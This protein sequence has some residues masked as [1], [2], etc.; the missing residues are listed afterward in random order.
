[1]GTSSLHCLKLD[2]A[3]RSRA[4]NHLVPSSKM[5]VRTV[6]WQSQRVLMVYRYQD[7]L[8]L[9]LVA[10]GRVIT[11]ARPKKHSIHPAGNV[12]PIQFAV[13]Y[14]SFSVDLHILMNTAH[15]PSIMNSSASAS[16][17]PLCLPKYN[18]SGFVHVFVTFLQPESRPDSGAPAPEP[19]AKSRISPPGDLPSSASAR[20]GVS[21]KVDPSSSDRDT[22]PGADVG[23]ICVTA[24]GDFESIRAWCGVVTEVSH[25]SCLSE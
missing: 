2:P 10:R 12:G 15:S 25:S 18:P 14:I 20:E 7:L 9:I 3:V 8:Y 4:A 23:L 19:K 21:T 22:G 5:K 1:M 16:W 17:L 24:N 6:C 13:S 11:L